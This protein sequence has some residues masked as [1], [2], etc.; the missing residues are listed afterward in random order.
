MDYKTW[1]EGGESAPPIT[2]LL[3]DQKI[4]DNKEDREDFSNLIK[5][6][7][8]LI[9]LAHQKEAGDVPGQVKI[10]TLPENWDQM[11]DEERVEF[12][13]TCDDT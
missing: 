5:L 4:T 12:L 2:Y 1:G 6:K 7:K 8:D 3:M 13:K 9:A 10:I 11:S